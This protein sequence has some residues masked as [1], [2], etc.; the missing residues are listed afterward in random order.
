MK[1]FYIVINSDFA[2]MM[3]GKESTINKGSFF[4][5]S[6]T[7]DGRYVCSS[8]TLDDFPEEFQMFT[9]LNVIPLSTSD[10]PKS[11]PLI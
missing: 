6:I 1:S 11:P 10:F 5:Y 8:N 7:T 4:G 9:E 2:D 3:N